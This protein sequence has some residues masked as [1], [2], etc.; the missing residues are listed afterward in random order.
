MM[1]EGKN[2]LAVIGQ[3]AGIEITAEVI[4]SPEFAEM[5]EVF[6]NT[7]EWLDNL[8]KTFTAGIKAVAEKNYEET[9]EQSIASPGYRYTYIPETVR[10][11]L[12]ARALKADHPD[13]YKEYV[14]V[15]SVSPT[16]RV[17]KIGKK[18]E[19]DA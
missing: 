5:Y 19:S 1:E 6:R 2:A 9:G 14:K 7:K 15:S 8:D 18:G 17:T 4:S 12:N 13:L 10:E 11:S 3:L 16:L